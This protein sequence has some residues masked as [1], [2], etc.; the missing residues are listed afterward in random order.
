MIEHAKT[1]SKTYG[2]MAEFDSPEALLSAAKAARGAGYRKMDAYAPMPVE[3]LAEAVGFA[4]T[5]VPLIVLIGGIIGGLSGFGLQLWTSAFDYP[6]NIGGRPLNS[7]PAFVPITFELAVLFAAFAAVF[8]ML[9]LNGLPQP[10][11]PV[12]NASR[13]GLASSERFFLCIEAIDGQYD[14][15]GTR[16]FLEGLSAR[17]VEEV[18]P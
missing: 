14:A 1:I 10:Y 5:K 11:H 3:G 2:L 7:W 16:A 4:K 8:G 13:F 15:A 6:V 12:F 17:S 18:A 9:A